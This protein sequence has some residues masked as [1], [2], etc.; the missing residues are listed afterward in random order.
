M[1]AR[2]RTLLPFALLTGL[3]LEARARADALPVG[4]TRAQADDEFN[5]GKRL[6]DA[7]D[8]AAACAKFAHS[9]ELDP[10]L[11]RL[12]NLAFCHE[13]QGKT[14][15]AWSESGASPV[16]CRDAEGDLNASSMTSRQRA[17]LS[18]NR[19]WSA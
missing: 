4:D 18:R 15:S 6:M 8:T 9:Q 13:Q 11:G 7:G 5:E 3:S 12:L 17:R 19:R 14:A 2:L 10:K 16:V 1:P